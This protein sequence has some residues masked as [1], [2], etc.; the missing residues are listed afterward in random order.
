MRALRAFGAFWYDFVVG[1]DWRIFAGT[2]AALAATA[3]LA[4]AG[5]PAWWLMP[6]AAASLLGWS[7]AR[8][9]RRH[10]RV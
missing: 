5:V 6:M 2:V 8:A 1:D 3:G 10:D 9:I 7:L 4:H